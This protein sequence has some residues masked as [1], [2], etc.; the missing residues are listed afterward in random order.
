MKLQKINSI[1]FQKKYVADCV[2]GDTNSRQKARI[3]ELNSKDDLFA[4]HKMHYKENWQGSYYLKEITEEFEEYLDKDT[5]DKYYSLETPEGDV[6]CLSVLNKRDKTN[7][8]EY[9]ETA[10]KISCYNRENRAMRFIGETMIAFLAKLTRL[11]GKNLVIKDIADR[12]LTQNFYF[13]HCHFTPVSANNAIMEN[14]RL[15]NLERLNEN[16]TGS[17]IDILC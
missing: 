17:T 1:F 13:N 12:K 2:V 11:E 15:T 14:E 3:F 4:L 5:D 8:L 10:P 9:I 7:Y 16:H 6:L